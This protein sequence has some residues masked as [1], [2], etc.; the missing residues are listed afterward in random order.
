VTAG[1]NVLSNAAFQLRN[2]FHL[3][4]L[5]VGI[6]PQLAARLA[7]LLDHIEAEHPQLNVA[8]ESPCGPDCHGHDEWSYCRRCGGFTICETRERALGVARVINEP[9]VGGEAS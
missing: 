5:R 3:P 8:A 9:S 6:D 7:D 4:G 2:P 1:A